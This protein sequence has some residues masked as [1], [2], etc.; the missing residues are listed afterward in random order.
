MI[1]L[2]HAE[3]CPFCVRVRQFL[4]DAGIAYVSKPVS[5]YRDSPLKNELRA[6]GGKSQVPFL[7]DPERGQKLYESEDIIAYLKQ[8]YVPQKP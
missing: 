5:L 7:V 1:E 6:L 8:Y 3:S 4:E 2:Y